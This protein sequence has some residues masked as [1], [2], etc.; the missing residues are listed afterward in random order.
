MPLIYLSC[1]WVAGIYLGSK[2]ALPLALIL[3]GLIPLPLLFLFPQHRKAIIL[4]AICLIALFGGAFCYQASLPPQD[5][6]FIKSYNDQEVEIKGMVKTDP[7]VRD[8]TTH[9]RL[10]AIEIR[11]DNEWQEVSG[12]ALLFVPRYPTYEYGDVLLVKG[13]LETPPQLDDFDYE[14]YLAHQGIYSTMLYPEIEILES[15]K[16]VKPLE[17]VYSLRNGLSQ[18]LT[19]VLPE[20]QAS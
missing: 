8:K 17:W 4:I 3:I 15:G 2:F 16:G 1:A 14:G 5:E 13:E 20:P 18:T 10:S 12:D 19:E 11:L 7:E 9:I 6:S